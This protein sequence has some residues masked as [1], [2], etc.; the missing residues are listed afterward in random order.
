MNNKIKQVYEFFKKPKLWFTILCYILFVAFGVLSIVFVGLEKNGLPMILAYSGMAVTFFYCC[1]LFIRYDLKALIKSYKNLKQKAME[2]NKIV[3][4]YFNDYYS[5][6]MIN[7]IFSLI[8]GIVFVSYNLIVGLYFQ[9]VWNVSMA[10]Y[11]LFL[12]GIRVLYLVGEYKLSKKQEINEIETNTK[13]AKL[14]IFGGILMLLLSIALLAPVSLLAMSKKQ[15]DLP[16][17]VAIADAAYVFYKLTMCIYSFIK[18][19]KS[20]ILSVKG[21]KNLELTTVAVALLS[22]ENTMI[23]TFSE[24]IDFSM[25][26]ITILTAFAVM[27]LN[28]W[29]SIVTISGGR[30]ELKTI[31]NNEKIQGK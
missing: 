13:R 25:K 6:V 17:W 16:M 30:K 7:T 26:I 11:Y 4:G 24:G 15:V 22:L 5:K 12:V 23:L 8:L 20:D 9:S 27:V 3:H 29:V 1:Y 31:N 2:K 14:F 21:I 10:V 28:I 18:T 19:R